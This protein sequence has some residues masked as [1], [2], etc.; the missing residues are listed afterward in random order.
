MGATPSDVVDM[1]DI[2]FS[3]VSDPQAAKDVSIIHLIGE[4]III[5]VLLLFAKL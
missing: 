4:C 3:C 5:V 1:T 2:I